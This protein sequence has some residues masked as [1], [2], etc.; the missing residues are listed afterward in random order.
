MILSVLGKAKKLK[1]LKVHSDILQRLNSCSRAYSVS[2]VDCEACLASL[3]GFAPHDCD[4]QY[5]WH[6]YGGAGICK[7]I[8]KNCPDGT[9]FDPSI[10]GCNWAPNPKPSTLPP[11]NFKI[12]HLDSA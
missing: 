1:P 12:F 6:C 2:S 5:F 8:L 11:G 10:G 3:D 9:I 4:D 7:A